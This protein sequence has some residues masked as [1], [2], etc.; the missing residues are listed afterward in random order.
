MREALLEKTEGLG[1][2]PRHR[3]RERERVE[4]DSQGTSLP[5]TEYERVHLG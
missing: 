4:D 1:V 3:V 2:N 5:R